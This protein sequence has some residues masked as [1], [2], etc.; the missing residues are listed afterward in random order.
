[1]VDLRSYPLP[2]STLW[3]GYSLVNRRTYAVARGPMFF[4]GG[5]RSQAHFITF[6]NPGRGGCGQCYGGANP[7]N[8]EAPLVGSRLL[9]R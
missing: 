5:G 1:M 4:L 3:A 9:S 8:K 2:V 6:A 7:L